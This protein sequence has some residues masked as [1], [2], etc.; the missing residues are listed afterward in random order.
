MIKYEASVCWEAKK[1]NEAN[2]GAFRSAEKK[3][4]VE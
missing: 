3:L 4:K 1:L 2:L